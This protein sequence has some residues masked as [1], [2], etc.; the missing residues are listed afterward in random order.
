M[1]EAN[2]RGN[3]PQLNRKAAPGVDNVD[4]VAFE[5][6][7]EENVGQIAIVLKEKRYKAKLVCRSFIPI[8]GGKQR[9]LGI[10]S[11]AASCLRYLHTFDRH[12]LI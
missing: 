2:L 1:N 10:P 4:W 6:N 9:P 12:G 11:G 7:L 5:E 8:P 3:F